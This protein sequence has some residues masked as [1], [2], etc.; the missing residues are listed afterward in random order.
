[1]LETIKCEI[2]GE[3]EGDDH[4]LLWTNVNANFSDGSGIP[5]DRIMSVKIYIEAG[6]VITAM[7]QYYDDDS[8]VSQQQFYMNELDIKF[9][10]FKGIGQE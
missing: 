8:T 4:A 6:D 9:N 7:V 1:M 5:N 3:A 10:A 2:N